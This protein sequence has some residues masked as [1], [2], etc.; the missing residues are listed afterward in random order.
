[1]P[2]ALAS[3]IVTALTDLILSASPANNTTPPDP[4][5][6]ST[7]SDIL[8]VAAELVEALTLDDAAPSRA[9]LVAPSLFTR[10]VEFVEQSTYPSRWPADDDE[11]VKSF[12]MV[13]AVS[14]RALIAV[15]GEDSVVQTAC[16]AP[17]SQMDIVAADTACG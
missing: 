9:A 13:K 17:Q 6:A 2:P 1:M 11:L 3:G 15:A 7:E 8:I 14:S 5:L 12:A 16:G 4:D 10:L